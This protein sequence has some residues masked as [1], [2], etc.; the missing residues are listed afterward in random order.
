MKVHS[1]DLDLLLTLPHKIVRF[2]DTDGLAPLVLHELGHNSSLGLT[3]A[4]YLIDNPD[5]D[6]LRGVAGYAQDECKHHKQDVW[7]EPH[8]FASDM[9]D[10][11]FHK[12]LAQFSHH[13]FTRDKQN[14]IDEA[15]LRDIGTMLGMNNASWVMWKMKH[16]NN[17][18]LLFEG[19]DMHHARQRNLLH[20]AAALL[21]LC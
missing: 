19:N 1:K 8:T 7:Q 2:Y 6:C 13:S 16:G 4:G 18:V 9:Q 14:N 21:S 12:K 5:F 11:Q 10:A 20:N 15:V 3:K 17:G